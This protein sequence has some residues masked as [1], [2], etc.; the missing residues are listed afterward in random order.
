MLKALIVGA[1]S[2][3]PGYIFNKRALFPTLD[4]M[5]A[6]GASAAYS[7]YVQKGY[8]GSYSSEQNWISIYTG[9]HPRQHGIST[10][11]VRGE[12]RRPRMAD[13]DDLHPFWIMLNNSGYSVGLW[14]ADSCVFP[15]VVNGYAA[16]V[17]YDMIETPADCRI[18]QR[19]WHIHEK[20][21]WLRRHLRGEPP[22]RLYPK[23]LRQQGY[24]FEDLK[25]SPAKAWHAIQ[26]YH[27]QE[28]LENFEEELCCFFAAMREVQLASPVDVLY[29]YTPTPDLI[30]HC[31]M[32]CDDNET[33]IKAYQLLDRH[34]G[35]FI[36]EF[37]PE[38]TV[39]LSDHGQQNF[40]DLVKCSD[41]SV[42][43]EAFAA[44]DDVIWLENGYIAFEAHNG[45]LLFT[46]HALHGVFIAH[47]AGIRHSAVS[48]MRTLDIYPT[49]LE[50]LGITVP[51]GRPGFVMDV[52]D[53]PPVNPGMLLDPGKRSR[54]SVALVQT[55]ALDIMDIVLNE[56]Y[57][58]LRF[59]DI[60]VV[61][62]PKYSEIFSGNPRVA[63]FIPIETFSPDAFDAVYCGFYN[64]A[65][66]LMKHVLVAH[67]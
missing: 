2:V 52:F 58:E 41:P 65:S 27:F 13:M 59:A 53:R 44:R 22:P 37:K 6:H 16:S 11:R 36:D 50:M 60:T 33:L 5:I 23:T 29:F 14:A 31:C 17:G 7:A 26:R 8:A 21:Q 57:N 51:P 20:E 30:A 55:H 35:M 24:S 56:L 38:L 47:G 46:A 40:K 18:A 49:I 12:R 64:E 32:Y 19:K 4:R 42:Q 62:E 25:A 28:A 15:T 39:F 54:K 1:D 45:A 43:R 3:S 67:R 34:M 48:G 63:G 9:L 61:G 66:G 10:N